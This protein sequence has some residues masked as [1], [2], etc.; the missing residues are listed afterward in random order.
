M[1]STRG[2]F[3]GFFTVKRIIHCTSKKDLAMLCL[4]LSPYFLDFYLCSYNTIISFPSNDQ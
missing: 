3:N 4:L 1:D 2:E